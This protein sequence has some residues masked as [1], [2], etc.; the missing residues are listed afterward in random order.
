MVLAAAEHMYGDIGS[1]MGQ[2]SNHS[3]RSYRPCLLCIAS[4]A[5]ANLA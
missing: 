5:P 2:S 3:T 1:T 4:K